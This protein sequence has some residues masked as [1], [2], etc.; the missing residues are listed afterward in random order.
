MRIKELEKENVALKLKIQYLQKRTVQATGEA[1]KVEKTYQNVSETRDNKMTTTVNVEDIISKPK[2]ADEEILRKIS[3]SSQKNLSSSKSTTAVNRQKTID[4]RHSEE[5]NVT[6]HLTSDKVLQRFP[7]HI[8]L[9]SIPF[10][11]S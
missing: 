3:T 9:Y 8:Q 5:G 2:I 4:E 10:F 11:H 1:V 6:F 7:F